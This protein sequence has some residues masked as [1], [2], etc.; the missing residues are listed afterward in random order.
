MEVQG[1]P[2]QQL[3]Q[4]LIEL[5]VFLTTPLSALQLS[6]ML[7]RQSVFDEIPQRSLNHNASP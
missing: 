4:A 5:E 6:R 3:V 7:M 2:L 1:I